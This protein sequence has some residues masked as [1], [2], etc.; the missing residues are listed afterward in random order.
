MVTK[1]RV[2]EEACSTVSLAD[3]SPCGLALGTELGETFLPYGLLRMVAIR[4][5][6]RSVTGDWEK[7][8]QS[9][10]GAR[11]VWSLSHL[12][13]A[14]P[15]RFFRAVSS[16]RKSWVPS[17]RGSASLASG[18]CPPAAGSVIDVVSGASLDAPDPPRRWS[19]PLVLGADLRERSS[20]DLV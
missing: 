1:P 4:H 15:T 17:N 14:A 10:V 11:R 7:V 12:T 5:F 16:L 18:C 9:C 20:L 3:E 19:A 2:C 13:S 8:D 6:R